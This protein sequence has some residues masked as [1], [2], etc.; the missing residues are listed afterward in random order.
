M[1]PAR[2]GQVRRPTGRPT[3]PRHLHDLVHRHH[4]PPGGPVGAGGGVRP[5]GAEASTLLGIMVPASSPWC[6]AACSPTRAGCRCGRPWSPGRPAR[7]WATRS[8][9]PSAAGW[10]SGCWPTCPTGWSIPARSSGPRRWSAGWVA[11]RCSSAASPRRC[12]RW[13]RA[14]RARGCAL[15]HLRGVQPGRGCAVGDRVCPARLRRRPGLGH[16]RTRR[17]SG[18]PGPARHDR[19]CGGRGG[20]AAPAA[21]WPPWPGGT[22]APGRPLR[23]VSR[24]VGGRL[25]RRC[26][27][28]G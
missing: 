11:G 6:W 7:W 4:S 21:P 5:A 9:T 19:R 2:P 3:R 10:G 1:R 26:G 8:G 24:A 12:G 23:A 25:R 18:R 27:T 20:A 16:G 17:R 13:C 22:R 14:C 15:P 28:G